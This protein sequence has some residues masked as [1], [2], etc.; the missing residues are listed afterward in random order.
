MSIRSWIAVCC[1]AVPFY[2]WYSHE[3]SNLETCYYHPRLALSC[4]PLWQRGNGR[5]R[6]RRSEEKDDA[7]TPRPCG[8]R[9]TWPHVARHGR[10]PRVTPQAKAPLPPTPAK[11][12][13]QP[14]APRV[15]MCAKARRG[16]AAAHTGAR[17]PVPASTPGAD[18]R[19]PGTRGRPRRRRAA[20]QRVRPTAARPHAGRGCGEA[21]GDGDRSPECGG[22]VR[23]GRGRRLLTFDVPRQGPPGGGEGDA[24]AAGRA[25][26]LHHPGGRGVEQRPPHRAGRQHGQRVLPRPVQPRRRRRRQQQEQQRQPPAAARR[27]HVGTPAAR[28]EGRGGARRG[29]AIATRWPW[30]RG[31]A[32]GQP[33][34]APG[35]HPP[36]RLF[37][38]SAF[39]SFGGLKARPGPCFVLR[40]ARAHRPKRARRRPLSPRATPGIGG[41][42]PFPGWGRTCWQPPP[43]HVLTAWPRGRG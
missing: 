5:A 16:T 20:G 41:E 36:S 1:E 29:R 25:V 32:P 33:R 17:A 43:R 11:A 12:P 26:E 31:L 7:H 19:G 18:G 42:G 23:A 6:H 3:T 2:P 9:K 13:L 38:A 21:G 27:R 10:S 14:S 35:T 39:R 34:A 8:S 4:V 40:E 37:P 15:T 22:P 24:V 28:G 30:R